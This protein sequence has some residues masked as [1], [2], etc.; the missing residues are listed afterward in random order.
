MLLTRTGKDPRSHLSVARVLV[1]ILTLAAVLFLLPFFLLYL[2]NTTLPELAGWPEIGYWQMFR[3]FL[4]VST[5]TG[6]GNVV[7]KG[8]TPPYREYI[9]GL[10]R[11]TPPAE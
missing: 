1:V 2:W 10:P 6:G 9:L 5:F 8:A 11:K 4:L 3:L 7:V